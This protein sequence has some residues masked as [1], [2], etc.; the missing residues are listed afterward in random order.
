MSIETVALLVLVCDEAITRE[1]ENM[2]MEQVDGVD[3]R[4]LGPMA[5]RIFEVAPQHDSILWCL[6]VAMNQ[7]DTKS[8]YHLADPCGELREIG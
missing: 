7:M 5:T 8:L 1:N 6:E 2:S 4:H 3:F